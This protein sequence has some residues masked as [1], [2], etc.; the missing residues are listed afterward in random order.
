L[1]V[2]RISDITR[3]VDKCN[4]RIRKIHMLKERGID[5]IGLISNRSTNRVKIVDD[6]QIENSYVEEVLRPIILAKLNEQENL[7]K[8]T[9]HEYGE[10]LRKLTGGQTNEQSN[11]LA[12]VKKDTVDVV[13]EKVRTFQERGELSFP[14]NYSPE[15]AMKSAWL[16]LQDTFD[17]NKKPVLEVCDRNSVANSLLNM[18]VQGLT[19]AKS[20]CYFIPYGKTLTLA[21]SYFGTQSVLK[22]V[23][24]A[25]DIFAQPVYEGDDLDYEIVRGNKQITKHKQSLSNVN[26]SKIVAAYATIIFPDD[27][28]DYTE[29]MTMD[30][31]KQAWKQS[32]MYKE[33]GNGTHQKFTDEMA[34]KTVINRACKNY[35][36]SSDDS[37]LVLEHFKQTDEMATE[38]EAEAEI[39]QNANSE[40]ID[41]D[42]E[43]VSEEPDPKEGKHS[44][45]NQEQQPDQQEINFQQTGTGGPGF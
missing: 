24:G 2:K 41:V 29:I 32:P 4:E 7:L 26:K 19:P 18:V 43:E 36:N 13:A 17:K 34:K 9:I 21:R 45:P 28:E 37:S 3:F 38:G 27:R 10:E 33:N 1:N 20:Q 39:Q 31:I 8:E 40:Y 15:N 11:D 12:L 35:I 22:R 6:L 42:A 5:D 16:V 14:A 44:K 23:T 25:E 30:Q